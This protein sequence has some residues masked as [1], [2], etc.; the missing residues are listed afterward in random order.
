LTHHVLEQLYLDK[1]FMGTIGIAIGEGL[2]TTDPGEAYTKELVM[3]QSRQ[4]ILLAD[5]SKFDKVSFVRAGSLADVDT[6]I[7]DRL[8]DRKFARELRKRKIEVIQT[9]RG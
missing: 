7:T 4:V 8:S 5:S 1:A 3:R 6:L 2:T 9:K